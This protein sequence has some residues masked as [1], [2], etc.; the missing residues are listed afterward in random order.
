MRRKYDCVDM[1]TSKVKGDRC[2]VQFVDMPQTMNAEMGGFSKESH[3]AALVKY[4]DDWY[5]LDSAYDEAI[6]ISLETE[7]VH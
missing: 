5:L 2:L 1:L 4:K 6:N 7:F 3:T